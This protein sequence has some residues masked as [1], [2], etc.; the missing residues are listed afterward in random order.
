MPT[1][2]PKPESSYTLVP[3]GT[4]IARCIGLINIG[5]IETEWPPHSG[6]KKFIFK[7]R[8]SFELPEE[9]HTFKEGEDAKPFVISEEYSLS[10]GEKANLRPIVEGLVGALT[11]A[12]AANFDVETLV[13]KTCLITIKHEPSNKDASKVY[14]RIASTAPLMKGMTVKDQVNE[15]KLL[16]YD[17]WDPTY[18]DSLP[19]FIKDKMKTSAE[20]ERKFNPSSNQKET[21]TDD[22]N[23]DSISYPNEEI[24]VEN[25][26]F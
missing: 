19:N 25:I 7:I 16:T 22:F 23:A 20:Y 26:P 1:I 17:N 5:T 2:A 11:E 24:N 3:A 13:G 4:H 8:L 6:I 15:S 12:K 21:K 10:M 14:S 18:F 9:T